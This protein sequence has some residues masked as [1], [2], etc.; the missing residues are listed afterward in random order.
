[1]DRYRKEL[2]QRQSQGRLRVLR[3]MDQGAHPQVC[4]QGRELVNFS[5]NDYLGLASHPLLAERGQSFAQRY[6]AGARASRLVC[7]NHPGYGPVEERLAELKGTEAALVFNSGFQANVS[8][9]SAL[10]RRGD[11]ILTDRLIHNSL[12][13]GALLSGAK[14]RR[15]RHNDFEHLR[16]LLEETRVSPPNGLIFLVLETVYSMDGDR[17]DLE[18]AKRLAEK[19]GALLVL[20]EAHAT[21]V[22]GPQGMGLSV[23]LGADLVIGTF[24]KGLGSF[25][26]Y[27]AGSRELM[28]YLVN[29]C[30]GLVYTTA[31]P[32]YVLGA[33]DAALELVPQ[34]DG[35]REHL[36]QMGERLRHGLKQ[37]GFDCLD[38]DSQI[39]PLLVGPDQAALDLA[40]SLESEGYLGMAIRP[41]TVETGKARIRLALSAAHRDEQVDGLLGAL[42]RWR[43]RRG[44]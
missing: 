7:G 6:G 19:Y 38:S 18:A 31:L 30:A 36:R 12:I 15:F 11:L 37:R 27:L 41:P 10:A 21:G 25:G 9:L 20:D 5:S 13:Q 14:F 33:I 28:D 24:G 32:P 39:V 40:Q 2:E 16:Q 4:L 43:E 22:M 23:G 17:S 3:T 35:Q 34:M 42:D 29:F 26:A 1:M 8:V 44:R